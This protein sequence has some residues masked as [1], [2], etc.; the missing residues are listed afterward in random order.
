MQEEEVEE[1]YFL[2]AKKNVWRG[3]FL[4]SKTNFK[5]YCEDNL[6]FKKKNLTNHFFRK[7]HTAK[8]LSYMNI[9]YTLPQ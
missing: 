8:L 6:L 9:T 7:K 3:Q 2:K 1:N 4:S 5:M